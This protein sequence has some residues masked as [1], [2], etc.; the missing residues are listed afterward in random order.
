MID[1]LWVWPDSEIIAVNDGDTFT[2]RLLRDVGFGGVIDWPVRLRLNRIDAFEKDTPQGKL[3]LVSMKTRVGSKYY[4]ETFKPYKYSGPKTSPGE[5][6]VEVH[7]RDGV[8]LS[9]WMV[10]QGHALYWDG[11]GKSPARAEEFND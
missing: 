2:A 3:A 7:L 11:M 1:A 8:L 4:M 6:M 5:W 10:E 9:D